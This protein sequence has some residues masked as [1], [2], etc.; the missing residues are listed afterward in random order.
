MSTNIKLLIAL[1]LGAAIG[2]LVMKKTSTPPIEKT[3]EKVIIDKTELGFTKIG[4][5]GFSDT[6]SFEK[7]QKM[8]R[9]TEVD[10]LLNSKAVYMVDNGTKRAIKSWLMEKKYV[11]G[12]LGIEEYR[13]SDTLVKG[14]RCYLGFN[15]DTIRGNIGYTLVC[16]PTDSVENVIRRIEVGEN[17]SPFPAAIEY[18][19]PCPKNCGTTR[20][21]DLSRQ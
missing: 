20:L 10:A 4:D 3:E 11:L 17:K 21:N 16:V 15:K 5:L 14:M 2:A 7:A 19:M 1:L 18:H 6:I 8:V 9:T 12:L 13:D